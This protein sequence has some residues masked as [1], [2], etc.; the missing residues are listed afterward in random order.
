MVRFE[1]RQMAVDVIGQLGHL[2]GGRIVRGEEHFPIENPGTGEV[3]AQCPKA[4]VADLDA[5]CAAAAGAQ[6]AWYGLGEAARRDAIRAMG[7]VLFE[8]VDTLNALG[9]IE[10]GVPFGPAGL[11]VATGEAIMAKMF[12]DHVAGMPIP[13][14]VIEDND[15][16]TVRLVRKPVGVVAAISSWNG[17]IFLTANKVFHALLVGNTIVA[18]PSPFAALTGLY[19]GMLWKD[20][21]PP[22]VVNIVAGGNELGVALVENPAVR[23]VSFTGGTP[24][25]R[26]VA[27]TA[28][29]ALKN[30][31]LELGGNDAA[32]VL[33]DVDVDAVAPRIFTA[34]FPIAGQACLAIKRLFVHESIHD[35]MV[36]ALAE[37]ARKEVAAPADQGGTFPPLTTRPQYDRV[38]SLV[39]DALGKGAVAVTGGKP[40]D[41]K[42][43]FYPPTILTGVSRAMRVV[44]EEQFGPVLPVI[45]YTD[46]DA[47]IAEANDTEYGLCGSVWSADVPRAT[48]LAARLEAG[49]VYA[50]SHGDLGPHITF[51][52]VKS[53][54]IGKEN[55]ALGL[56]AYADVQTQFVPK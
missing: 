42:G 24:G 6:E 23:L 52:G 56:D 50:N 34:A 33:P 28:A 46:V 27:E 38:R 51:G 31:V 12:A 54:G 35:R 48:A 14:D 43:F 19:L 11:P 40:A 4:S 5:A 47:A 22:G 30:V 39:E 21:V 13:V 36:E 26:S 55:G 16:R 45:S 1:E 32:I 29:R 44:E 10:K 18:K 41:G 37:C 15:F 7:A 25:G 2:I 49:T 17:P 8:N 3:G 20:I 53:S 9:E